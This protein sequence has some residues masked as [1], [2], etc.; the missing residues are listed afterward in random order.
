MPTPHEK[1]HVWQLPPARP[2]PGPATIGRLAGV[3]YGTPEQA[4]AAL[5][6]CVPE[7][8]PGGDLAVAVAGPTVAVR[9]A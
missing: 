1:I 2:R 9:A 4:R 8:R 3:V 7:Y 6:R 5:S